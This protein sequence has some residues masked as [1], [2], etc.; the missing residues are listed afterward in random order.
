MTEGRE[1]LIA[2]L[3]TLLA[4]VVVYV[5]T[6]IA[7]SLGKLSSL[8]ALG[9]GTVTGGLIGVLQRPSA[10]NVTI[11]QPANQPVPVEPQS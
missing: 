6:L 11:D 4:L 5:G 9:L 8:E 10:R 2:Y 1:Q 7:A 3:A